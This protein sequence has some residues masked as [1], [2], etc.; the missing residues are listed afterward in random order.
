LLSIGI[1]ILAGGDHFPLKSWLQVTY[2]PEGSE[3]WHVAP[4]PQ[5][6]EQEGQHPLTGQRVANFRLLANQWAESRL[7]TQ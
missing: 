3:F 1:N 4:Q 7:V 5:E 2:P 6:T